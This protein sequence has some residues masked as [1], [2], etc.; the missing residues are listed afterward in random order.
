MSGKMSKIRRQIKKV[1][2]ML[3]NKPVEYV[4]IKGGILRREKLVYHKMGEGMYSIMP[5]KDITGP[6]DEKAK[7]GRKR[8]AFA[9]APASD[10]IERRHLLNFINKGSYIPPHMHP[11]AVESW[12]VTRGKFKAITMN[13]RGDVVGTKKL[14]PLSR[15]FVTQPGTYHTIVALK[16]GSILHE[17]VPGPYDPKTYKVQQSWAP[18]EGTPESVEYFKRLE[19]ARKR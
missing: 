15:K 10:K 19:K 11:T 4:K 6:L 7:S 8:A 2:R 12:K 1:E 13:E 17:E 14:T 3:G 9:F 16:E 5:L 18:A